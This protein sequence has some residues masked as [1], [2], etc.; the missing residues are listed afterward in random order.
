MSK[1]Y[2]FAENHI[3]TTRSNADT[4]YLKAGDNKNLILE[5]QA[6]N[7]PLLSSAKIWV[8]SGVGTAQQRSISGDA[9]L[10]NT[11]VLTLSNVASAGSYTLS[12]ITL[13]SK[14]RVTSASSTTPQSFQVSS[15]SNITIGLT[16]TPLTALLQPI[17]LSIGLSSTPNIGNAS[18]T[19]LGLS[20]QLTSSVVTGTAPLVINSTT[21]V[22]NLNVASAGIADTV[23]TNADLSG[24][25]T[26][27]GNVTNVN[28]QTGTGSTFVMNNSPV[29]ITPNIGAATGT[30]LNL[31][32]RL[33]STVATGTAPF[34]VASTSQ[35]AN[36]N[37]ATAGSA[38][39]VTILN[40]A[41]VNATV[42]PT[43]VTAN[44]GSLP[45]KTSSS[46]ISFVPG[47]AVLTTGSLVLTNTTDS[48]SSTTGVLQVAG[49][50]GVAKK[51]V[52]GSASK[53]I[54]FP[55]N[56]P[57]FQVDG[58]S[59][60]DTWQDIPATLNARATG[61]NAPSY[62]C[63]NPLGSNNMYAYEFVGS[64]ASHREVWYEVHIPHGY[65]A[66][67]GI[68][69]HVHIVNN[70]A[71]P[72]GN[73]KFTFDYTYASS[74]NAFNS[75]T[76]Q[77]SVT[78]A[79]GAQYT[80]Q[81]IEIATPVL[82]GSLEVDG[83]VLVKLTRDPTDVADTFTGSVWVMY[84]DCHININKFSTKYRNKATTGSFYS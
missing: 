41:S 84:A 1:T 30:T 33:T 28:S 60:T 82:A 55:G 47:T 78:A 42:Y 21:R 69:F 46:K 49:G 66:G 18:G 24:V 27:V 61:S 80:H 62:T 20:G 14:G 32:G 65:A 45:L 43:W 9:S 2:H 19:T 83:V 44:A 3:F 8:G 10:N 51:I 54:T 63:W 12:N 81:I 34:V 58:S 36:L 74:G 52:M 59:N 25:I 76:S 39:N 15:D 23:I 72:T 31:S 4:I 79:I 38:S 35:V 57:D 64:G 26:S 56:Q 5:G 48:T 37:A 7:P 13:D 11:G 70:A 6:I 50:I 75:T 40:D 22:S 77:T 67:T 17:E 53:I 71:N 29:L 16:G 73:V 68:Y